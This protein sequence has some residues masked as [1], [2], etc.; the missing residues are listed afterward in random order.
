[1]YCEL[2]VLFVIAAPVAPKP[3]HR[4]K[5]NRKSATP[6]SSLTAVVTEESDCTGDS[7]MGTGSGTAPYE[8]IEWRKAIQYPPPGI[9]M[10]IHNMAFLAQKYVCIILFYSSTEKTSHSYQPIRRETRDDGMSYKFL[11]N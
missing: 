8:V 7:G 2:F 10:C 5:T 11:T 1:M 4:A 3:S 9:Y 6:D